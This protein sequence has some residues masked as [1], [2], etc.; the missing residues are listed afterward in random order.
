MTPFEFGLLVGSTKQASLA[1]T[2]GR[3]LGA[4]MLGH[5]GALAGVGAASYAPVGAALG[6]YNAPKGQK[7]YG[8]GRGALTGAATGAGLGLGS[9]LGIKA[10]GGPLEMFGRAT[11]GG[12]KNHLINAIPHA[13]SLAG[14]YGA[15]QL[16]KQRPNI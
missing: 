6:A 15:Y 3:V 1:G 8:A 5:P 13:T 16:A 12:V 14:G 9:G 4:A 11:A 10:I 2:A 7:L